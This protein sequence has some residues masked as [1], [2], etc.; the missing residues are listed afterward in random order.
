MN[1]TLGLIL[2]I[3]FIFEI[4]LFGI[5]LTT[6][7]AL[8]S[9]PEGH[10]IAIYLPQ[11]NGVA[12]IFNVSNINVSA[13][14]NLQNLITYFGTYF[15]PVIVFKNSTVTQTIQFTIPSE[16]FTSIYYAEGAKVLIFLVGVVGSS[17][18]NYSLPVSITYLEQFTGNLGVVVNEY[19]TAQ[20]TLTQIGIDHLYVY[21]TTNTLSEEYN[22]IYMDLLNPSNAK[23]NYFYEYVYGQVT[24]SFTVATLTIPAQTTN[25]LLVF[26]PFSFVPPNFIPTPEATG[27]FN[28]LQING[29]LGP[30]L[31][32]IASTEAYIWGRAL[33]NTS[34]VDPFVS[35]GYDNLTFQLN[36]STPGPLQ[37][38]LAQL[39]QIAALPDF[40]S[41]F[42][43][44][45]YQFAS[46]Y[47]SFLGFI[48]D[49][50]LSIT[51]NGVSVKAPVSGTFTIPDPE[52][53]NATLLAILPLSTATSMG[54][55]NGSK[56][57]YF[58]NL[59]IYYLYNNQ[60]QHTMLVNPN[61]PPSSPSNYTL[62]VYV[63]SAPAGSTISITGYFNGTKYTVNIV[64]G[65]SP[66]LV[67]YVATTSLV[68][69]AYEGI[70]ATVS[71]FYTTSPIMS[72]PPTQIAIS[73]QTQFQAQAQ[74]TSSQATATVTLLTNATLQF[75]NVKLPGFSFSGIVVT[76]EYP[77]INGTIAMQYMSTAQYF[78]TNGEYELAILGSELPMA[79]SQYMGLQNFVISEPQYLSEPFSLTLTVPTVPATETGTG[80]LFVAFSTIPQYTY[81]TLVDF[82]LWSNET[83]VVVTAY[84]TRGG[85]TT[86]NHGYFYATIIP[87]QIMTTPITPQSFECY[88]APDVMLYD[89]DAIL[90]P[91]NP[92]GS[93]TYAIAAL[94][95]TDSI[96]SNSAIIFYGSTVY[97]VS[98]TFGNYTYNK[99]TV[100]SSNTFSYTEETIVSTLTAY[101]LTLNGNTIS[102]I[103]PNGETSAIQLAYYADNNPTVNM[104][105]E[106]SLFVNNNMDIEL[107][108]IA[109]LNVSYANMLL[110]PQNQVG[111]EEITPTGANYV[112]TNYITFKILASNAPNLYPVNSN[113]FLTVAPNASFVGASDIYKYISTDYAVFHYFASSK[114]YKVETSVTVPNITATLYFSSTVTP[115]YSSIA[116]LY[117]NES[118]YG[119]NLPAYLAIGTGGWQQWNAPLYQ[120]LGISATP[121][122]L[123]KMMYVNVTLPSG[124]T[125]TIALTTKNL[126]TLFVSL[127]AQQL[128]YCNGTYEYQISIP[129]LE[130]I[131]HLTLQQLNNSI[132]T[133]SMYDYVTHETLV[134]STKLVA[135][136]E[137][138]LVAA[139]PG[140][141]FYFLTFKASG[142]SL[143]AST[144]WFIAQNMYIE[145]L[146]N[147]TDY[148]F[149]HTN[150]TSLLHLM[151]TNITVYHN[152][153]VAMIY[154]NATSGRTIAKNVYGQVV[155]NASG[156]LIPQ[157]AETAAGSGIFTGTLSFAVLPN[158]TL[159]TLTFNKINV[160]TNGTLAITL[161][162]GTN[163]PLGPA[164]L[165]V[166]PFVTI[167]G[168]TIGY[169]ANVSVTVTD[170]VSTV[171]V[172]TYIIPANITPIRLA[173]VPTIPPIS[174][175]PL[176]TYYYTSPVV[177]TP[178]SP[179]INIYATS[180][181][182]YPYE[183]FILAVVRE[184]V[185]ASV[186]SPVV[187][188]S[189]QAVVAKPALGSSAVPY[190]LV[191]VQM[192]GI[193]SLPPGSYTVTMYAVPFAVGPAISEYPV[194]LVFTNV[195]VEK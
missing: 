184:G 8:P 110:S 70:K 179:V 32:S 49:D 117:L 33:I 113:T 68:A 168:T 192:Q 66:T 164:G 94:N 141:L 84:S 172:S 24:Q 119:A 144:P 111:Y 185:N 79:I 81:I 107:A 162:N 42:T 58:S 23:P 118:Y 171:T 65:S 135:L 125:Y 73:G 123:S 51:I 26:A 89:P 56:L 61:A 14:N 7:A 27:F 193:L 161:S 136:K 176:S 187:Y 28:P 132:L 114:Q 59:T 92:S 5:P 18:S 175:A 158:N 131:L 152:G 69:T 85:I 121:L 188:Y 145:P 147:F 2:S 63:Y 83:S 97:N 30:A 139:Q 43:Y 163:V 4:F 38:N 112:I 19:G 20:T 102:V 34:I 3:L 155:L 156:N 31:Q 151:V 17:V 93:F 127:N 62:P 148:Q 128:Q 166:L 138:Q 154:Y 105:F 106:Q 47:W 194:N 25:Q 39:A 9:I 169:D 95:Y 143:T 16:N 78:M 12:Y 71:G 173:P 99:L 167:N 103:G 22:N 177:I 122:L 21:G 142:V 195:T 165:F 52:K 186:T 130:N 86:V 183:F 13:N 129:G 53:Y 116:L 41:K 160:F 159:T 104:Y 54:L 60:I 157:I 174:H 55:T 101:Q 149:A 74:F 134:A 120:L 190:I 96:I 181:L 150:P 50:N 133:V 82:G 90:V 87:P 191:A 37:I 180:I 40:P 88:N 15:T 67:P 75:N 57:E 126:T 1:K 124:V 46:G 76:P 11:T 108:Y 77:I 64:V 6:Q 182:P 91:G 178:T 72:T 44:L 170:S 48:S 109:G 100:I 189:Y 29:N 115:L 146:L 153:Q 80:P 36:Y 98:G 35:T 10:G 45:S 137:L 140:Q